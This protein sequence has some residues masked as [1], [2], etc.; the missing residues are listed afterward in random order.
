MV[1]RGADSA[2]CLYVFDL[3]EVRE[4]VDRASALIVLNDY[5]F[6]RR[7]QTARAAVGRCARCRGVC[8]GW[9][10]RVRVGAIRGRDVF[11]IASCVG[12]TGRR[13]STRRC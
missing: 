9:C 13:R 2:N 8:A 6:S 10:T 3:T 4:T 1:G 11:P 5:E 12:I 7:S